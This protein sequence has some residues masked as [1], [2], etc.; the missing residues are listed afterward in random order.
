MEQLRAWHQEY[1]DAD[2]NSRELS[3][4]IHAVRADKLDHHYI[5]R[6]VQ[7][8]AAFVH[9]SE[10]LCAKCQ[11][12]FQN[13]SDPTPV[14]SDR[15]AAGTV[16]RAVNTLELEAAAIAGCQYCAMWLCRINRNPEGLATFRKLEARLQLLESNDTASFDIRSWSWDS[17]EIG[18]PSSQEL[19]LSLPGKTGPTSMPG[20]IVVRLCSIVGFASG[21][22]P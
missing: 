18:I 3:H 16:G 1:M 10:G 22:E 6:R 11:Y 4:L 7:E 17:D 8:L 21:N 19:S 20:V 2:N 12:D 14:S 13:W 5:E 9:I 15:E